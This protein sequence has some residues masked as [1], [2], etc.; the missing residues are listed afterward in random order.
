LLNHEAHREAR[1]AWTKEQA[2][3]E[4]SNDGIELNWFEKLMFSNEAIGNG[5][6][7]IAN[8]S[9]GVG[10]GVSMGAASKLSAAIYGDE[11]VWADTNSGMYKAGYWTGVAG[12]AIPCG[13]NALV[14]GGEQLASRG[15][16]HLG[17]HVARD[18]IVRTFGGK[19]AQ[20]V[21]KRPY[22]ELWTRSMFNSANRT[23]NSGQGLGKLLTTV[24]YNSPNG[25]T[26][27]RNIFTN[28]IVHYNPFW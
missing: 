15:A 4:L 22:S 23:W 19:V 25:G 2:I 1:A 16:F 21:G 14:V 20:W 13:G 26:V 8:T 17:K 3:A 18:T 5:M 24:K 10:D 27:V 28:K 9:G 6:E 11:A 7:H 12:T